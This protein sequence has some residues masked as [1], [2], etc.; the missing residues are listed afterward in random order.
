MLYIDKIF[1]KLSFLWTFVS[2]V[3]AGTYLYLTR[4]INLS[5]LH[6]LE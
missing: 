2:F 3:F 1:L 4:Q 5:I 6:S